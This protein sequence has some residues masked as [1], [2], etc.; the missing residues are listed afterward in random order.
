MNI[1]HTLLPIGK[2][3]TSGVTQVQRLTSTATGGSFKLTFTNPYDGT[4]AQTGAIAWNASVATIVAAL[5][6][7][8]NMPTGADITGGGGPTLN[9][10]FVSLT[11]AGS[12]AGLNV[13]ALTVDNT[14]ATGGTVVQST[15]TAGVQGTYRGV[16]ACHLVD[17]ANGILYENSGTRTVPVWTIPVVT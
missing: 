2:A 17:T 7:L 8:A 11:M 1:A 4:T 13:A 9:A 15:T 10:A 5:L 3:P 12:L 6:A 14:S 16:G